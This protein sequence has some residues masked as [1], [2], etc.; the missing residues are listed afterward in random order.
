MVPAR[1]IRILDILK[2]PEIL[3]FLMKSYKIL[4]NP[5]IVVLVAWTVPPVWGAQD[6][7]WVIH[8][9]TDRR[10]LHRVESS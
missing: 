5:R 1:C 2:N 9:R 6:S 4:R 8:T 7:G 3:G 10:G